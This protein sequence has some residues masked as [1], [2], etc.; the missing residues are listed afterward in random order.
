MKNII[1]IF[2]VILYLASAL[3][4]WIFLSKKTSVGAGI[5]RELVATKSLLSTEQMARA[6]LQTARATLDKNISEARANASFLSLAFCPILETDKDALC[7]RDSTEWFSQTI[8]AGT[9]LTNTDTRA[10]IEMLLVSLG[11]KKKPTAKELYELLKP[12]EMSSLKAL[13]ES[14]R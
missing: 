13:T 5:A 11:N 9:T 2:L 7:V 12:V 14:L 3:G 8:Q 4:V 10:K 6:T 1:I